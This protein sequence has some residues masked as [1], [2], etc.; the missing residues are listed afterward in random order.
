M[1]NHLHERS[2]YEDR[3][4]R[5][6]V[7][8]CRRSESFFL[9][10]HKKEKTKKEARMM[11]FTAEY[12]WSIKQIYLTKQWYDD[13]EPTIAKWMREDEKRDRMLATA[14]PPTNVLC[15]EC[16]DRMYEDGRTLYE[17]DKRDEVLFFMRCPSGHLPMKGVFE[18]G[19]ERKREP[20][21]CP[22]CTHEMTVE[23]LAIK[24]KGVKTKYTC[25]NCPYEEVDDFRLST[26]EA[27]DPNYEK[28]RAR[29]CL[30]GAALREVQ[31]SL[32][33]F[34]QL[35]ALVDGWEHKKEHQEEYDA[36]AKLEKLT[37]PQVKQRITDALTNTKYTNLTFEK[38]VIERFVSIELSVE[39]FET[40][41][42]RAS[43]VDLRK[44]IKRT[45]EPTNWRLMTGDIDYRLGL[46]TGRI[47]AYESEEDMLKL[48]KNL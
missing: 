35:K 42:P 47:R 36:V 11:A 23:R 34:D 20:I 44:I 24:K 43:C 3:Y 48:V 21:L 26:E 16:Y 8:A 17:R 1:E 28:D 29:F 45:L 41:N 14:R 32:M 18:D 39:E 37:I 7:E 25:P 10:L 38:P 19:T 46:L 5:M 27:P 12:A 33:R 22:D 15:D 2:Y 13:K 6:T 31:D 30:Q 40:D 4:D 9:N